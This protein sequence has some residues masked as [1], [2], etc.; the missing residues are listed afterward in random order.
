MVPSAHYATSHHLL[1]DYAAQVAAACQKSSVTKK[2]YTRTKRFNT[3]TRRR[4]DPKTTSSLLLQRPLE[5]LGALDGA[6]D[7]RARAVNT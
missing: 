3:L 5:P 7:D 6:D 1:L 2:L 4:R